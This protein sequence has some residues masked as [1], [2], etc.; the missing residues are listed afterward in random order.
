MSRVPKLTDAQAVTIYEMYRDGGFSQNAIA[1][2]FNIHVM[3]VR[4]ILGGET[5]RHLGL[6][7]II[8]SEACPWLNAGSV[9]HYPG[10]RCA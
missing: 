6:K 8:G 7:P 1:T 9:V 10:G 2:V 5:Y 3:T 4:R